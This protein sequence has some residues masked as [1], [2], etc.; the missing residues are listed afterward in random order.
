MIAGCECASRPYRKSKTVHSVSTNRSTTNAVG[1]SS[2]HPT[3]NNA[4]LPPLEYAPLSYHFCES[5]NREFT[6]VSQSNLQA[7]LRPPP[8]REETSAQSL[9]YTDAR[10]SLLAGW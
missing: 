7:A 5:S 3:S 8:H 10:A 4:C 6:I 9:C 1:R 2:Y